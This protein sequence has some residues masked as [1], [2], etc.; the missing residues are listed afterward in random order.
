MTRHF[1]ASSFISACTLVVLL[2]GC[3]SS[4]KQTEEFTG[5]TASSPTRIQDKGW[6]RKKHE[7]SHDLRSEFDQKTYSSGSKSND[8]KFNTNSFSAKHDYSGSSDYKAKEFSQSDKVSRE[9][10]ETFSGSDKTSREGSKDYSTKGYTTKESGYGI[11]K[12]RQGDKEFAGGDESYKTRSL[13]DAVK[14][15]KENT[16]PKILPKEDESGKSVYTE[17]DVKRMVNRN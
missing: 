12:A 2:A 1:T 15:Q 6:D 11:Q 10:G 3:S 5:A 9:G 13:W 14:S 4:K 17:A 8:K 16:K 7:Y